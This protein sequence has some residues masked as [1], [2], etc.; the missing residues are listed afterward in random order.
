MVQPVS[1][2][3]FWGGDLGDDEINQ[4]ARI[5]GVAIDGDARA[6]VRQ[7]YLHYRT[8]CAVQDASLPIADIRQRLRDIDKHATTLSD[9][10]SGDPTYFDEFFSHRRPKELAQPR[11][12]LGRE[13]EHRIELEL[14]HLDIGFRKH[15]QFDPK[16][17]SI[18]QMNTAWELAQIARAARNAMTALKASSRGRPKSG[19]EQLVTGLFDALG[20]LGVRPTCGYSDAEGAYKGTF[21]QIIPWL[22]GASDSSSGKFSDALQVRV[23]VAETRKKVSQR[24]RVSSC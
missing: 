1:T 8:H 10:L 5:V 23:R 4:L 17:E 15:H 24:L 21:L 13:V 7:A 3:V 16:F 18:S 20:S 12:A 19:A 11:T 2:T 22:H 14:I 9:L 6:Q